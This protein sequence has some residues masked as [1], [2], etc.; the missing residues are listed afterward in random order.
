MGRMGRIV[1]YPW[2]ATLKQENYYNFRDSPQG[3][4]SLSPTLGSTA[5]GSCTGTFG[6]EDQKGLLSADPV[7]NRLHS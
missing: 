7:R 6:F 2:E 1:L 5:Q 4:R 3:V